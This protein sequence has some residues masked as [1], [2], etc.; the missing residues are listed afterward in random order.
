VTRECIKRIAAAAAGRGARTGI[1]LVPARFQVADDD[2]NNLKAI[3]AE[4]GE[5][6]V[7]DGATE[8][9]TSAMSGLGLP[10]LD[11]LPALRAAS[12]RNRVFMT[13]TAH[14]TRTG[15]EVMADALAGFLHDS[16]LLD[17]S[18]R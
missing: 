16:G 1:V 10:M 11:A 3:A 5:E 8:R 6:L 2:Y 9:F 15:H 7:R 13:S 18:G 12:G 4:S 17:G 14:F